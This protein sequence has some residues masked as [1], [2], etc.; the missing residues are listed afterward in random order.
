M[1]DGLSTH[2]CCVGVCLVAPCWMVALL[3][4]DDV[5]FVQV[6]CCACCVLAVLQKVRHPLLML[7]QLLCG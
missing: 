4:L 2:V 3:L 1:D 5:R 6:G 7:A